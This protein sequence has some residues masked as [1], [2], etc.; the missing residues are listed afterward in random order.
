MGLETLARPRP[1]IVDIVNENMFGAL[2]LVSV[3]QGYDPR[4]FALVA[5]GGAGPL[6]A[7]ALGRLLGSWPVIIPP[8]PG[9]AVR[10]RRRHHAGAQRD[11]HAPSSAASRETSNDEVERLLGRAGRP[12]RRPP[13]TPT[14]SA[15]DQQSVL[16]QVDVRY[17][18]QGFEVPVDVDLERFRDGGLEHVGRAV[19]RRAQ[20]GCSPSPSKPSTSS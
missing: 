19:R 7:N 11:G 13:S 4:D 18:G 3:E 12:R 1:G 8:S 10:L 9:R 14:G 16:Y 15:T 17:H 6:H 2:R 5:F 20:A